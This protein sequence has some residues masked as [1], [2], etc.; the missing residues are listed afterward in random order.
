M[1]QSYAFIPNWV[2]YLRTSNCQNKRLTYELETVLLEGERQEISRERISKLKY[3]NTAERIINIR[4]QVGPPLELSTVGPKYHR[5][6]NTPTFAD[7]DPNN[8]L[9]AE[10]GARKAA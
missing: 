6:P 8:K 2:V 5:N 9:W 10:D 4:E 3:T 1:L 7:R